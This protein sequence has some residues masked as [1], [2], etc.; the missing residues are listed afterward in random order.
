[1]VQF[2]RRLFSTSSHPQYGIAALLDETGTEFIQSIWHDFER[3]F[4]IKHPFANPVPHITH[5]QAEEIRQDD[6]QTALTSFAANQAPYTLHA[7]GL[8]I[9]TGEKT[10][11]YV[12]LVRNL[13]LNKIH[14]RLINTLYSTIE[15]MSEDHLINYWMPHISLLIPGMAEEQLT[16][17]MR[18]LVGKS[19]KRDVTVNR[20]ALLDGSDKSASPRFT[21]QLTG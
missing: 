8:G 13:Q 5:I 17:V 2:L 1:M 11:V 4:G 7:S 6:L 18:F 14:S 15:G 10:A 12:A 3:E 21:V 19:F 16:D 20:L 9:F